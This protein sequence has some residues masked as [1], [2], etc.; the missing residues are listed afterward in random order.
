MV[1]RFLH[2]SSLRKEAA[3]CIFSKDTRSGISHPKNQ[4]DIDKLSRGEIE[5]I[6]RFLPMRLLLVSLILAKPGV[7]QSE[8]GNYIESFSFSFFLIV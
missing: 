4:L 1:S 3:Q 7:V 5:V 2:H 8:D 6:S